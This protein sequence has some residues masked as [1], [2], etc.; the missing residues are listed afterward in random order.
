MIA[1]LNLRHLDSERAQWFRD[2]LK[3]V[4]YNDVR[5]GAGVGDLLVTWNRIGVGN[6]VALECERRG[7]PVLVCENASWGATVPGRWLHVSRTRHNTAGLFPVA[8][9]ERWDRLGVELDQ[10]RTRGETVVLGQRGIGSPPVAQ[11]RGWE[12][13]MTGRVRA[14]PGRGLPK[15]LREDLAHA[16][17]V[18]TWGSAA[19]VEALSWGVHVESH[20][21]QWI[22]EQDNTEAG[23]LGMFQR[24]A[25]AQWRP[26]EIQSGEAFRWLLDPVKNSS[27]CM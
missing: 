17:K 12:R 14:H 22:G 20:M 4:G 21:P 7:I 11:P 25:W 19:A 15:P 8:G 1:H 26:E 18:V 27:A 3:A 5:P 13:N 2:G 9:P 10:F 6:S 24:M 23:R 16:G